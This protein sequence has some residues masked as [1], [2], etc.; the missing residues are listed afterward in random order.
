M[1]LMDAIESKLTLPPGAQPLGDYARFYAFETPGKVI[2]IYV[3]PEPREPP[4]EGCEEVT[5]DGN[6]H[7][8]ACPPFRAWPPGVPAGHRRWVRNRR[9]MPW[10]AD[11]G[12]LQISVTYDLQSGKIEEARCNGYA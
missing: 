9:E 8:V 10:M 7:P 1:R 4:G 2:A 12:C 3:I 6:S 11:G 5:A